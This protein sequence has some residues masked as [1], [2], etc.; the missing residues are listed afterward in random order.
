MVEPSLRPMLAV[1]PHLAYPSNH[2]FQC[3]SLALVFE[4]YFPQHPATEELHRVADVVAENREWAGLHYVSDTDAG[5]QLAELFLPYLVDACA[6][7]M[8]AALTEWI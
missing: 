5:R 6:E 8:R 7:Q 1:P 3:H 2:S 4:R